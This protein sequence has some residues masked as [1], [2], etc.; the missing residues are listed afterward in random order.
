MC[1]VLQRQ[2]SRVVRPEA[3]DLEFKAADEAWEVSVV[4]RGSLCQVLRICFRMWKHSALCFIAQAVAR[5]HPA[6]R[7]I[8]NHPR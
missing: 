7:Y 8:H 2:Q 4:A 6:E 1:G 3:I 5:E